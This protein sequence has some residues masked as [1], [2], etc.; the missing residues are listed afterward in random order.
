MDPITGNITHIDGVQLLVPI[1]MIDWT[2]ATQTY[3]SS[4]I[5]YIEESYKAQE[6]WNSAIGDSEIL[7]LVKKHVGKEILERLQEEKGFS[8]V[9]VRPTEKWEEPGYEEPQAEGL[10]NLNDL[11]R[12]EII[13]IATDLLKTKVRR[14]KTSINNATKR[15]QLAISVEEIQ[16]ECRK[17]L[18]FPTKTV[19]RV[20]GVKGSEEPHDT[21]NIDEFYLESIPDILIQEGWKRYTTENS[22]VPEVNNHPFWGSLDE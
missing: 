15:R 21:D 3:T 11:R 10:V 18:S 5:E 2:K 14:Q 22:F 19:S 17:Q 13:C 7:S 9:I 20:K 12:V 1:S 16:A 8:L 4:C 6:K